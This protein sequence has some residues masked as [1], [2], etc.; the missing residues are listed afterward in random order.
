[1]RWPRVLTAGE[2]ALSVE[3]GNRIE[4]VINARVRALDRELAK[5]PFP[6]LLET[7]P[8]YRSL[9]V[10]YD[11]LESPPAEVRNHLLDLATRT[12]EI[13]GAPAPLKQVPTVYDGADLDQVAAHTGLSR[14]EIIR[15]H[16]SVEVMVY[17]LGF[18]PGFAYMGLLPEALHT[19][20]QSTPRTRIAPGTVAIAGRQTSVYPS[21]TP[22]GWNLI[23]RACLR[24]FD[25][26]SD[27]PTFFL[28]GDRVRFVPVEDVDAFPATREEP[29]EPK[30]EP[31]FEVIKRR[32]PQTTVQDLG[33]TGYQRYGVPVAGAVDTPA[34]RAANLMVGNSP[35]AAGLECTI[36]GP[37]VLRALRATAVA[38][39]GADLGAVLESE[40]L[41]KRPLPSWSSFQVDR[42]DVLRFTARKAGARAYLAIAGGLDVPVVL[43]SRAT[44]LSSGLGGLGGRSLQPG[45]VL[46]SSPPPETIS[47][48]NRWPEESVPAHA[49]EVTLR[50]IFGPQDDYFT[51]AGRQTL[52]TATYEMASSSD[53]MGCRLAGPRL[54]HLEANEIV[55]D[56]MMLGGVQVPPDGQPIVML[57]DRATAGG[58]PKIATVVGVDIPKLGQLMP[59]DKVCFEAVSVE[60][61]VETLRRARLEEEKAT[62][63]LGRVTGGQ[64]R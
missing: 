50:V 39:T 28:P 46:R 5:T 4:P 20:R 33:R 19:A 62:R 61:A 56:G 58:Y 64:T 36:A 26:S 51:K 8:T 27:P 6:G 1:V 37:L 34:L 10:L 48:G 17:M 29:S 13:E 42:G 18:S 21:A 32:T 41:L 25:P 43:G 54:E 52:L 55:S 47:A 35:G 3:F 60:E 23:G 31:T 63:R 45:D 14:N 2:A 7:V 59:G 44:Y 30:G 38:I 53:R 15:L 24:L 12:S 40:G 16:S 22:S 11:P 57:A 9:L 49:Q